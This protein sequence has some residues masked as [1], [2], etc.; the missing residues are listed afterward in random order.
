MQ[1]MLGC[2]Y[3]GSTKAMPNSM[4]RPATRWMAVAERIFD[5]RVL[6]PL[7]AQEDKLANFH[8]NTQVPKLI[9]LARIHELTGKDDPGRAARFFWERVTQHHSYVG[10]NADRE[11]FFEP[12]TI[13]LHLTESTCEHCNTYNMLKLT[14]HLYGWQPTARCSTITSARISTM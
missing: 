13:A 5:N 4:P 2:E 1:D 10:G 14:R 6:G 12:D 7:V 8:A 3:G 9:G 11:Y